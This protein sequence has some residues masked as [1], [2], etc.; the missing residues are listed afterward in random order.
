MKQRAALKHENHVR[1]FELPSSFCACTRGNQKLNDTTVV[2]FFLQ[3]LHQAAESLAACF[4]N[5]I[6]A[7]TLEYVVYK[8]F[9]RLQIFPLIKLSFQSTIFI[10]S[11]M[12]EATSSRRGV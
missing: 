2:F 6:I 9:T 3:E 1:Q 12:L 8:S 4:P 10:P 5:V 11:L 7:S